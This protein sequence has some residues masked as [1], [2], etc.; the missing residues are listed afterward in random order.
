VM[1]AALRQPHHTQPARNRCLQSVQHHVLGQ[2][3]FAVVV[4][5]ASVEHL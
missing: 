3:F 4:K 1:H 5:P 2:Q